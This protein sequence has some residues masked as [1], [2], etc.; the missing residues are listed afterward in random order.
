L[1]YESPISDVA[2]ARRTAS[3]DFRLDIPLRGLEERI[4]RHAEQAADI[5]TLGAGLG[6]SPVVLSLS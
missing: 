5:A 6:P 1:N 3:G 2:R 4:G